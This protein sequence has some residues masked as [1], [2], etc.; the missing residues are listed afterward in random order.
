MSSKKKQAELREEKEW[1]KLDEAVHTSENFIE[2]YQKQI[3]IG[4]GVV[5]VLYVDTLQFS[6]SISNLKTRKLRLPCSKE[7]NI[8]GRDKTH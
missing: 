8:S 3:L 1:E 4:I 5:V 7:K 6:I 2:K